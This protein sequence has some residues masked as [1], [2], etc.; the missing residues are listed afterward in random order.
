MINQKLKEL[1]ES[2]WD[3]LYPKLLDI[4]GED[5]SPRN[6][7]MIR[8]KDE[9]DFETADARV[10]FFG[11]ETSGG[12]WRLSDVYTKHSVDEIMD[13]CLKFFDNE[14]G[15]GQTI[16]NTWKPLN[17]GMGQGMNMFRRLLNDKYP[18]KKIRYVWNNIV[19]SGNPI[20]TYPPEKIRNLV[21]ENFNVIKEEINIMKPDIILFVTG[22][23][24]YWDIDRQFG[25]L[26]Y[27]P[28]EGFHLRQLCK[29]SMPEFPFVKYAFRMYHLAGRYSKRPYFDAILKE[30]NLK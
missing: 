25:K 23:K 19:K 9:S 4:Q 8:V 13:D 5:E 1:Y 16:N 28:I 3:N 24:G 30:I 29:V 22:I 20:G 18:D 27:P 26:E 14:N 21:F 2:K 12:E 6:P 10:M 11:R 7:L 15:S 17:K